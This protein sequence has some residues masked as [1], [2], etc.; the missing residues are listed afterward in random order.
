MTIYVATISTDY[1]V[2]AVANTA[3]EATHL[4]AELALKYINDGGP[5]HRAPPEMTTVEQVMDYFDPQITELEIGTAA[6]TQNHL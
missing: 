6:Y 1:E 5:R 3:K 4:A 2:M